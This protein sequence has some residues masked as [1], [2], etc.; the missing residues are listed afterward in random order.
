MEDKQIPIAIVGM[1]CRFPGDADCNHGFWELLSKGKSAWSK[2]PN[3]RFNIDAYYH[4]SAKRE[5][6]VSEILVRKETD[7]QELTIDQITT[8]SGFYLRGDPSKWDAGFFSMTAAEAAG[9]D[10]Q[11]RILLELAYEAFE[12]GAYNES[13]ISR[14]VMLTKSIPAGMSLS[15]VAGSATSCYI[16]AFNSDYGV[17]STA[18]IWDT[19]PYSVTGIGKSMLSNRLSW[20]FDLRGASMTLDTACSSSLVGLH[21]AMQSLRNGESKMVRLHHLRKRAD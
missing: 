19:N 12:N 20:F 10:P 13:Q 6:A 14:V 8:D 7:I 15:M 1:S 17:T 5:G 18:Q 2:I 4:P 21:L 3:S 16:G 9:T 11:Q